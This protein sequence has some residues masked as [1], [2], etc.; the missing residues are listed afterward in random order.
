MGE[1]AVTNVMEEPGSDHERTVFV[2]KPETTGCHVSKE[3]G[4][5]RV[6]EPRMVGTG[7]YQI[8]KAELPDVAE[9]LQRGGVEQSKRKVLHFYVTVDRVLDY[10]HRFTKESSNTWHKSIE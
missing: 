6:L 4:T 7:I 3:H 9:A 8:G 5:E 2:R 10:F 1:R